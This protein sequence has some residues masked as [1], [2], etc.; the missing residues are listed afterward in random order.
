MAPSTNPLSPPALLFIS[1][2]R[3]DGEKA[4]GELRLRLE[5]ENIPLWQDC[6]SMEGGRDWWQQIVEALDQVTFMLLVMTP[7]AMKSPVVR[8]EWR[9][10]RQKG[11]SVFPV[12]AVP[13][14]EIARAAHHFGFV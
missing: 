8:K 2:A 1:Y 14:L 5:Q 6:V 13:G 10:A 7:A 9:L 3:D 11:V 12:I 4:A